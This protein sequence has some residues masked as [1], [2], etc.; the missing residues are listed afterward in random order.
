MIVESTKP[1]RPKQA[2]A[3]RRTDKYALIVV[4]QSRKITASYIKTASFYANWRIRESDTE[5]QERALLDA[6]LAA[7]E[8]YGITSRARGALEKAKRA[9]DR[10]GRLF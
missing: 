3:I 7:G 1:D 4:N 9:M 5:E 6:V 8:K 2:V 10:A